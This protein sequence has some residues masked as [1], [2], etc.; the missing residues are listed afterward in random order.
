MGA[1][2]SGTLGSWRKSGEGARSPRPWNRGRGLGGR[3]VVQQELQLVDPSRE[4]R[5][6]KLSA[7]ERDEGF[8]RCNGLEVRLR[9]RPLLLSLLSE[10]DHSNVPG[11]FGL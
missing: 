6:E 11:S 9:V 8:R 4:L 3:E 10:S 5:V 1:A 2:P 7:L